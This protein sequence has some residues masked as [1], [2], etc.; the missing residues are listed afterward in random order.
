MSVSC[1]PKVL[2]QLANSL[3]TI[4]PGRRPS[5]KSYL[6]CQIASGPAIATPTG[7]AWT[8]NNQGTLTATSWNA[9]P[10]G[11]ASTE[12][13]TSTDNV[14]FTL[15]QTVAAPGSSS[16]TI[17]PPTYPGYP[18]I[19]TKY[20]KIRFCSGGSCSNFTS[21]I[22]LNN[23]AVNNWVKR[24]VINGAAEPAQANINATRT[25]Y[26]SLVT[27]NLWSKF[28]TMGTFVPDSL[29]ASKTPL[30]V[31]P[32]VTAHD[33]WF[34]VTTQGSITINGF[35]CTGNSLRTGLFPSNTLLH[36]SV[37][38]SIYIFD[39]TQIGNS[40]GCR[41]TG[42]GNFFMCN[43]AF[44]GS[45]FGWCFTNNNSQSVIA[46]P[47]ALPPN[48]S[49]MWS[50]NR[51]ANNALSVY[52]G[53]TTQPPNSLELIYTRAGVDAQTPPNMEYYFCGENADG[54]DNNDAT[55]HY[56]FGS[57]HQGFSQTDVTNLWNA[58]TTLRQAY[59]GG[60]V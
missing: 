10:A 55:R 59:G 25:F 42:N 2:V 40:F 24:I 41:D 20:M 1:D 43:P 44:S 34:Q 57:L 48:P 11:V 4:P 37:G 29:I 15:E 18:G 32:D 39:N 54:S 28:Y 19:G 13:W 22:S 35:L 52:R 50:L 46:A 36:N 49:G 26:N 56:S 30:I 23:D 8:I 31:A 33:P 38:W 14:T 21:A 51:T 53:Q 16:A 6:L 45:F 5:V 17:T 12:I 9:P 7:L 58:V 60:W 3:Q 47:Q 27:A